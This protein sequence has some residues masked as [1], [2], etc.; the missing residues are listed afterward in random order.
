VQVTG[1]GGKNWLM[2]LVDGHVA[3]PQIEALAHKSADETL[4]AFKGHKA[5]F[6]TQTGNK[7]KSIR[8]DNGCEWINERFTAYLVENGIKL[9]P[10]IPYSSAQNGPGE[11][12]ICTTVEL[13]RCLLADSGLPKS[14]WPLAFKAAIYL[15][16]FHP[17]TREASLHGRCTME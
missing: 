1:V 11:C 14:F 4:D 6:E 8:V 16:W 10:I 7:L 2:H 5:E 15:Q 17:K 3:G 13:G 12:S 9:K